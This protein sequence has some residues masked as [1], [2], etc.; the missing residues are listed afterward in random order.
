[1]TAQ[2]TTTADGLEEEPVRRLT[3]LYDE[4]CRTCRQW[5]GW[6]GERPFLVP[7]ELVPAGSSEARARFP[8]VATW[9]GRELVVVDDRGRAWIGPPAFVMCLWATQHYRWASSL[10]TRPHLGP[11]VDRFL[12]HLSSRRRRDDVGVSC[13][14]CVGAPGAG[15]WAAWWRS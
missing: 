14:R 11:H 13:P 6:L 3:I 8:Q 5:A 15:S 9:L 1:M 4:R 12:H 2:R 7:V 10:A